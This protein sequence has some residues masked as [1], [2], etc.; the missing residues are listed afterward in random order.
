MRRNLGIGSFLQLAGVQT[1]KARMLRSIIAGAV[2]SLALF[3]FQAQAGLGLSCALPYTNGKPGK[4]CNGKHFVRINVTGGSPSTVLSAEALALNTDGTIIKSAA[5]TGGQAGAAE[6]PDFA[7]RFPLLHSQECATDN[8]SDPADLGH[9]DG[10]RRC[11]PRLLLQRA[12]PAGVPA[13]GPGGQ[14]R[15]HHR[16]DDGGDRAQSRHLE[17]AGGRRGH[18]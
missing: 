8:R 1:M 11:R 6:Q 17:G 3:S 5:H 13:H 10:R 9:G 16:R 4:D 18:P 7:D 15:R 2:G 14:C 12:L